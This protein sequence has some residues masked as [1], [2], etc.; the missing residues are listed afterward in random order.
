[1]LYLVYITF[2]IT[3]C[4]SEGIWLHIEEHIKTSVVKEYDIAVCGGDD[5]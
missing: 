2:F 4:S 5:K 1:M 3:K